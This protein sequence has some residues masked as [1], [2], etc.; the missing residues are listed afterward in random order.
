M[1]WH[2]RTHSHTHTVYQFQTG[3]ISPVLPRFQLALSLSILLTQ[4]H[5][6]TQRT[7]LS[8]FQQEFFLSLSLS[9]FTTSLSMSFSYSLSPSFSPTQI[10][11]ILSPSLRKRDTSSFF[12]RT[13]ETK[14]AAIKSL[15]LRPTHNFVFFANGIVFEAQINRLKYRSM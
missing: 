1:Q 9:L 8:R 4:T 10:Q 15:F 11:L 2:T 3:I 5:S 12:R 14:P 13:L 7:F 6:N